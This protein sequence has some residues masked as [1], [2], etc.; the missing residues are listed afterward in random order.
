MSDWNKKIIANLNEELQGT[1]DKDLR[2]FRIEEYFRMVDRVGE[3]SPTCAECKQFQPHIEEQLKTIK[4]AIHTPGKSRRRYDRHIDQLA[5]HMKKVHNFYPPYYF[6][7]LY[8]FFFTLILTSFTFLISLIFPAVSA[9]Y[10]VVPGFISGLLA[11]Q[12]Y[13]AKKDGKVRATKKIL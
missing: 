10:F 1:R 7:Y 4:H 2:F 13:G 3:F 9:W 12:L 6:T 8:S 11:G 5:R